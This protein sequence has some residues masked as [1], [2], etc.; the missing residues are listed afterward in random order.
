[1]KLKLSAAGR[2]GV[3]RD[4]G[5]D[6]SAAEIED[7]LDLDSV[8][9]EAPDPRFKEAAYQVGALVGA[10]SPGM[11]VPDSILTA[12][13]D[14]CV[15]V[16]TAGRRHQAARKLDRLGRRRLLGHHSSII[17]LRCETQHEH[18]KRPAE[19]QAAPRA[20][21]RPHRQLTESGEMRRPDRVGRAAVFRSAWGVRS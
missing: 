18:I 2:A 21:T 19:H 9:V 11:Y 15:D 12:E 3:L 16:G 20:A 17:S 5:E 14:H 1:V 4:Y 8:L 7:L 10:K 6:N 13:A